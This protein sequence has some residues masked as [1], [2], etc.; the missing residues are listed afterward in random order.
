MFSS[1]NARAVGLPDLP[2]ATTIDVAAEAGFAAV[3]LMV[4]DLVRS[5]PTSTRS[6]AGWTTGAPRRG[7]P[8]DD[9]L[10]GR[11]GRFPARSGRTPASR[12]GRGHAGPD[13]DGNLGHARD[14]AH[15]APGADPAAYRAEVAAFHVDR[16]GAI[17]RV[18]AAHGIRLGLE[19]IGVAT[20]RR[21]VGIP[22]ITRMADLEP[23]L[24]D[25]PASPTS[26]C[27]WTR[28]TSTPPTNHSPRR[29]P[30]E[31]I[32]SSGRT[33]PTCPRLRPRPGGDH[34]RRARSAR[35]DG[36]I[37]C[38]AFLTHAGEAGF[39]GPVTAEPLAR[40]AALVGRAPAEVARRVKAALDA[41]WP[42]S[43]R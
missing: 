15:A 20:F 26:A 3:D 31:P 41:C 33:S 18:L 8:D 34:R 2:V 42:S 29:S 7:V 19:V 1:F 11:R 12:R 25:C 10:A 14:P 28:S 27:W 5:G 30:G 17:A 4:R 37:D 13:P 21:G 38:R 24:A 32:A 40:C 6:G 36:A 43:R 35:S 23:T 39:D 9:G 16:L 22:F